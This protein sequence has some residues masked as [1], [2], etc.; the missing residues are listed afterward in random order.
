MVPERILDEVRTFGDLV[1]TIGLL[2]REMTIAANTT[3]GF[4]R[5]QRRFAGLGKRGARVSI[6][7][8]DELAPPPLQSITDRM[9]EPQP[10]A[11]ARACTTLTDPLLDQLTGA[12]TAGAL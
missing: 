7:R 8:D 3:E 6:Q 12:H 10:V 1:R 4:V 9:S 5:A 11:A 2:I